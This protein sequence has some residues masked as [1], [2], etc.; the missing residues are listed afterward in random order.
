MQRIRMAAFISFAFLLCTSAALAQPQLGRYYFQEIHKVIYPSPA[1][2]H[3]DIQH[4]IAQAHREN[5][6]ILLDF[7]GNW[8]SDCKVLDYYFHEPPNRGLLERN[9]LLVD[10]NVGLYTHNLNL[11]KKYDIPLHK[12]VPALA[13]LGSRGQLLYSSSGGQ[14]E[15]MTLVSLDSVTSFLEMW[16][17]SR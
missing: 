7:G 6:R 9:F 15:N 10:I 12:G 8:C 4:A 13:V 1:A 14:F 17:P 2:A 11:A 5:K 3:A 16:K